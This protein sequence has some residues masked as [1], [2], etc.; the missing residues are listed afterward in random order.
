MTSSAV[1]PTATMSSS[2]PAAMLNVA[3]PVSIVRVS[4]VMASTRVS[5]PSRLLDSQTAPDVAA[6]VPMP[7]RTLM[8][9]LRPVRSILYRFPSLASVT[10]PYPPA[11]AMFDR[12]VPGATSNGLLAVL[13]AGSIRPTRPSPEYHTAPSPKSMG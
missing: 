13:V 7:G 3:C 11:K 5:V 9:S 2:S 1:G 8:T 4:L 10:Q 6:G 12:A